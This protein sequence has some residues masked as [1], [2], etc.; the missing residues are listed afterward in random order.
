MDLLRHILLP[1][2]CTVQF[3]PGRQNTLLC[4][5]RVRQLVPDT[6]EHKQE[7]QIWTGNRGQTR[8]D[9]VMW[10][11]AGWSTSFPPARF[12]PADTEPVEEGS[13]GPGILDPTLIMCQ[14]RTISNTGTEHWTAQRPLPRRSPVLALELT[15]TVWTP[16]P[17]TAALHLQLSVALK[18][19]AT[20][21]QLQAGGADVVPAYRAVLVCHVWVLSGGLGNAA[22]LQS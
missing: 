17:G 16:E 22:H 3:H 14:P 20:E 8:S 6:L 15:H 9:A 7:A 11:R 2:S 19:A 1:D 12:C 21:G 18:G 4:C 10:P 5:C 13:P